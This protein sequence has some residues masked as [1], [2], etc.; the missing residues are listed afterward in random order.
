MTRYHF[1]LQTTHSNKNKVKRIQA[2][3]CITLTI[4]LLYNTIFTPVWK[5]YIFDYFQIRCKFLLHFLNILHN[6]SPH[7]D[8]PSHRLWSFY[9]QQR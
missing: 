4:N 2:Y 1:S 6:N 5:C 3:F 7:Q 8:F 9:P